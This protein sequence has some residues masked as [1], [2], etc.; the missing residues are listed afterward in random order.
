M[1]KERPNFISKKNREHVRDAINDLRLASTYL[2]Q[3]A[4]GE[5]P[6]ALSK[7]L[8]VMFKITQDNLMMLH[9]LVG[10]TEL[11]A[12]YFDESFET[13]T[14]KLFKVLVPQLRELHNNAT[15]SI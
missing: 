2:S 3:S 13:P 4:S 15:V 1:A 6:F 10:D 12:D 9:M 11:K 7:L 5:T 14:V 8:N